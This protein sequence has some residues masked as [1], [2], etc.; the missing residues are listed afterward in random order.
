[1]PTHGSLTKA[2]KVRNQTP[3]ITGQSRKKRNPKARTRRNYS[4]SSEP[5]GRNEV[6]ISPSKKMNAQVPTRQP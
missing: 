6:S 2:G 1:M 5:A 3:T 4:K